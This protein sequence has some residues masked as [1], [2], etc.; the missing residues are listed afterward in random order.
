MSFSDRGT[1][2]FFLTVEFRIFFHDSLEGSFIGKLLILEI[3]A[4]CVL[5]IYLNIFIRHVFS[6]RHH[7]E[8]RIP[9]EDLD[10]KQLRKRAK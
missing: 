3:F 9:E 1:E 8:R 6:L 5:C 2:S 10:I 7:K 4:L